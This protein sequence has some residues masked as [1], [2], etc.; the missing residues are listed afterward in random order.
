MKL[1][2]LFSTSIASAITAA[3]QLLEEMKLIHVAIIRLSARLI[4]EHVPTSS[5][6]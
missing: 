1:K 2:R 5:A 6:H 4:S 3:E